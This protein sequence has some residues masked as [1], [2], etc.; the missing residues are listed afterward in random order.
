MTSFRFIAVVIRQHSVCNLHA[1]AEFFGSIWTSIAGDA[2]ESWNA[3]TEWISGV[4]NGISEAASTFDNRVQIKAEDTLMS[5]P[6]TMNCDLL[7][8]MVGMCASEGTATL[9]KSA[10]IDGLYR[11]A[12]SLSPHT[13]DNLTTQPGLYVAG[14]CKRPMS[15]N[16]TIQDA[17]AAAVAISN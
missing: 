17:R 7:V 10:G 11:F 13:E 12:Q 4:W 1:V 3:F 8:L 16:D 15:I 9:S 6:L 2:G 5:N 14:A